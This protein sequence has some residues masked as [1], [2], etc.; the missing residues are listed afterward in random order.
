M[1]ELG[2]SDG[3]RIRFWGDK[4]KTVIAMHG[5]PGAVGDMGGLAT[6]LSRDFY[7]IEPWQRVTG[8]IP[9]NVDQHIQ[10][11][12]E[13]INEHCKTDNPILVGHSW[14]AMLALAYA[15]E[16]PETIKAIALV[17]CGT[18]DEVSRKRFKNTVEER[19]IDNFEEKLSR[20]ENEVTDK[21]KQMK[22]KYDL[23]SKAYDVDLIND[24]SDLNQPF[25]Y[26]SHKATWDDMM[27]LMTGGKY[28]Q[29]FTRIK[30][31]VA[32]FHGDYDP[33]PGKMIFENLRR[34][35]PQLE[36]FEFKDCG[37]SP[38]KEKFARNDFLRD[39]KSWLHKNF[40]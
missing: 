37:H 20:I 24:Q 4:G 26:P 15:A 9:V 16:Y 12:H 1:T 3:S 11:L 29:E 2:W 25:D 18:F 32:M 34:F 17:G 21:S 31:P 40:R 22:L 6:E 5:G 23:I 39:M 38:W 27:N 36:Y 14:G 28:P 19:K 10:D 13:L 7:V 35:M 8:S 30:V 33:H